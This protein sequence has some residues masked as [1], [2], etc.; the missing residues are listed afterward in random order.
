MSGCDDPALWSSPALAEADLVA[1]IGGDACAPAQLPLHRVGLAFDSPGNGDVEQGRAIAGVCWR[2]TE[3]SAGS[4][5]AAGQE[6]STTG[7]PS[8]HV[9]GFARPVTIEGRVLLEDGRIAYAIRPSTIELAAPAVREPAASTAIAVMASDAWAERDAVHLWGERIPTD[10]VLDAGSIRV[11]SGSGSRT[12]PIT[13]HRV[14]ANVV[15]R[16]WSRTNGQIVYSDLVIGQGT[17]ARMTKWGH[18]VVVDNEL[19]IVGLDSSND[20][21]IVRRRI[22]LDAEPSEIVEDGGSVYVHV[23]GM[24]VRYDVYRD[25]ALTLM[26]GDGGVLLPPFLGFYPSFFDG[27]SFHQVVISSTGMLELY[28]TGFT[29]RAED[30]ALI[31]TPIGELDGIL[32]GEH[33]LLATDGRALGQ[34]LPAGPRVATYAELFGDGQLGPVSVDNAAYVITHADGSAELYQAPYQG[35]CEPI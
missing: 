1:R 21:A 20:N 10:E 15:L 2:V 17:R 29:P 31:G 9:M 33:G 22:T 34:P 3:A 27:T 19:A 11:I 26:V 18:G 28:P 24:I 4:G 32:F 14:G 8:M 6:F 7:I 23:P 13:L 5:W 35:Y 12:D 25:G 30:L 16:T